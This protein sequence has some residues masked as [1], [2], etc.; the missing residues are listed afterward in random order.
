MTTLS[1]ADIV[2]TARKAETVEEKVA[3]LQ[4]NNSQQLRDL[5]ALMCD[6]RWTFDLPETAPP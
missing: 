3:V 5:L 4:K 1:L 6:S 2:N